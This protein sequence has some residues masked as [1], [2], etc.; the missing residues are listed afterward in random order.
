[1]VSVGGREV[2]DGGV[3]YDDSKELFGS[4]ALVT[5]GLLSG[6]CSGTFRSGATDG[7]TYTGA[8]T[9]QSG[10]LPRAALQRR[11]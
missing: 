2:A 7:D 4:V 9:T 3:W 1:M 8:M 6:V 11:E 10:E 5:S